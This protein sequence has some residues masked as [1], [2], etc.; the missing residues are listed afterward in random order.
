MHSEAETKAGKNVK[1]EDI[2]VHIRLRLSCSYVGCCDNSKN[3]RETILFKLT[4]HP[5]IKPFKPRE[6]RKWC[7]IVETIKE[8]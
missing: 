6:N 2:W 4:A 1:M 5:I 3:K 7:Y 8:K